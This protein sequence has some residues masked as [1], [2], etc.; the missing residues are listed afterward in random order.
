MLVLFAA[1]LAAGHPR[2]GLFVGVVVSN[3]V[4][5]VGQEIRAKRE[6]DKLAVLSA[7]KAR[8]VRDGEISEVGVSEVV[9][10][11]VLDL[12]P[13]DQVVVD[14]AVL[15]SSGLEADESLLTGEADP[16]EKGPGD[17]LLSGSFVA[18]GS[19]RFQATRIGAESYASALSEEA[20]R[21]NPGEQ[22]AA[23]G[24]QHRAAL[25]HR[26]HPP[27][28]GAVGAGAARHRGSLAERPSGHGGRRRWPWCPTAWCC[29]P[30]CP[31]WP[32]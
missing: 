11:E 18:A 25:A 22:R 30:A 12:A 17:E 7:P 15:A 6:L 1:I 2:D 24:H 32:G 13:G 5:G 20:R 8:V 16:I 14:G 26:H 10:D 21:F 29:S 27:G 31:S 23:P 9:A 3:A 4:I 19:G 28:L